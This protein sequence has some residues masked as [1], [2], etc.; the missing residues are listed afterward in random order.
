MEKLIDKIIRLEQEHDRLDPELVLRKR[1]KLGLRNPDGTGVVA[2]ITS[3]GTVKAFRRVR[4][5]QNLPIPGRLFYCGIDIERIVNGLEK[6]QRQGFDETAYLLLA[7]ELPDR[8]DL[9][10]FQRELAARRPLPEI[11]KQIIAINSKNQDQMGA[12]HLSIASLHKL[13]PN[14]HAT[15]I[16]LVTV[17][18]ID[19][20]AKIPAIIAYNHSVMRGKEPFIEPDPKLSTAENFLYMLNGGKVPEPDIAMLFDLCLIL[21]A[22]HGG[23][24]NSTFA[25]RTV[26]SSLTNTY[27]TIAAGVAS[28]AGHLHG[29]ANEAVMRMM[30]NIKQEVSDWK[31][32]DEVTLYLEG[33]MDKRFGDKSGKI[34]GM[35]HPVYTISDPREII[36]REKAR[37]LAI[38]CNRVDDFDL[39]VR[40]ARLSADILKKR[41]GKD[42]C[43]NVDFFSGFIYD[44]MEIPREIYTPIFA[45]SRVAGWAAHRIE[46][47]IQGRLIRPAYVTSV[48]NR[49]RYT[50]LSRR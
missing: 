28:L 45:M 29:G 1:I 2:G 27:M 33:L 18:C 19:L 32:D 7:G 36:L 11:A 48:P 20:I 25:V 50:S 39:Y 37:Q 38:K 14:P 4:S 43:P 42:M 5:G 49:I 23:G 46:E 47:I 31:D 22:E 26:S 40:V 16:G 6:E 12:L 24:N 10:S 8:D 15:D 13:D 44:M 35:G 41:K 21:H 30:D 34:Y 3:K 17:Q 9:E